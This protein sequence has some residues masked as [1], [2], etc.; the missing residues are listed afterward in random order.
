M[1]ESH[2]D[3]TATLTLC[4]DSDSS[5]YRPDAEHYILSKKNTTFLG[6]STECQIV[7]RSKFAT[8]SRYHAKLE[9]VNLDDQV[10]WQ[11]CD[12]DTPNG[13]FV[14]DQRIE[15][16][17]Q[18]Q[19]GDRLMLGK[20]KGAQFTF[21][22]NLLDTEDLVD[23]FNKEQLYKQTY[24]PDLSEEERTIFKPS[25][26]ENQPAELK[27][28]STRPLVIPSDPEDLVVV[29]S[30]VQHHPVIKNQRK[31]PIKAL[32]GLGVLFL[33]TPPLLYGITT[34]FNGKKNKTEILKSYIDTVSELLLN[35]NLDNLD[36]LDQEA[37]KARESANGQV[38]IALRSL[39]GSERG[40]L[41]RF[42]YD[43]KIIRMQ[44]A[45]LSS[46]WLSHQKEV[47]NVGPV[48]LLGSDLDRK[49]LIYARQFHLGELKS[50]PLSVLL[51]NHLALNAA[52][53]NK[54]ND[55]NVA[56]KLNQPKSNCSWGITF[57]LPENEQPF[58]TPIQLS[59]ANIT[60]VVL[61]DAPLDGINLEGAYLSLPVCPQNTSGN[62][63][64]E[65]YRNLTR[66]FSQNRCS[67]DLSNAGLQ[68]ARLFRSVLRSANLSNAKL[69]YADLRQA[70]LR[71]ANLAGVQWTGSILKGACYLKENWQQNFPAKGPDGLPFDPI[72]AG[73]KPMSIQDSDPSQPSSFK[74]CKTTASL[75]N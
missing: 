67:A 22:Y 55:C 72:A 3:W 30:P 61:K 16:C 74:E 69:D 7:L 56:P 23:L 36:P 20:P 51:I 42:L 71:G 34:T 47:I 9:F 1:I 13:T 40:S 68:N 24:V 29:E 17:Q 27:V 21:E 6:R 64:V 32:L 52:Q 60:G 10:I 28:A 35:R 43:S 41:V 48:E 19:S 38:R 45:K 46:T 65:N 54:K 73:M 75:S 2:G 59:G 57:D 11:I 31:V 33:I 12:L 49:E 44:P 50:S 70:D 63:L 53:K 4:N 15:G 18:L 37:R 39:E 58:I 26:E 14:N 8:V 66:W 25:L 62:F 5:P